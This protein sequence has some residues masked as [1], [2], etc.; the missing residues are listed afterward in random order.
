MIEIVL[1]DFDLT[2]IYGTLRNHQDTLMLNP[3]GVYAFYDDIGECLYVGK[4]KQLYKRLR[5]HKHSEFSDEIYK[6]AVI[7]VTNPTYRDI[8]ETYAIKVL[9]PSYNRDKVYVK[10]EPRRI[11]GRINATYLIIDELKTTLRSFKDVR[12]ELLAELVPPNRR[13]YNN[14][15][16]DD[17]TALSE[18]FYEYIEDLSRFNSQNKSETAHEIDHLTD[19]ISGVESELSKQRRLLTELYESLEV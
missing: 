11:I 5:S 2:F 12:R 6:V 7:Y 16:S 13:R 3:G 1:P 8:Y 17:E 9:A 19:E 15:F 4:S 14:N 18:G 10:T